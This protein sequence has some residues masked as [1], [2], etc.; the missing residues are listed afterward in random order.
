MSPPH[1]IRHAVR[2]IHKAPWFTA[3]SVAVLGLGIGA[4]TAIFSLV[5]AAL[6]R[7]L[8]FR[9]A[10][11]L[12]MIWER[13]ARNPRNVV[14]LQTFAD[15][16]D[17]S[18]TLAGVAA[19]AG[20]VQIP[21]ARSAEDVPESV[22]LESVTPS[23]FTVLGV[24]PLLGRFP[25]QSNVYV[26]GQSDGG[27]AISERLWRTRFGADPSIVGGTIRLGS[28]PRPVPVVGILPVGFQPLGSTDI[29][30]VISVDGASNAR[31]TRVLRVIGRMRPNTTLDQTRA[32]LI[33]IA[34]NIEQAY[35]ATN[36]GWSVTVEPLQAAIVGADLR[37]TSLVLGGVVLFVLLLAC[38]NIANLILA[39]GVGR[40][41]ELAVRA[42]LGGTRLRIAQ[43]LLVECV[44]LGVLGGLAG[45]AI[46]WALL[47]ATP[48]LI[49]PQTIPS[50][51]VLML[52]WR[53]V[54]F[55]SVTTV[56]TALLFGLA[57]AWQAARVS[58]VEAMNIGG[59]GASDRAGR[60][61]QALAVVEIA[62]ALLLMT[63]A[64]LLLRT[65][66]SLNDVDAGYRADNVVTMNIR[67]PFRRLVTA[68]PGEIETY[69][70]SIEREVAS[71]PAVRAASLGS[72]LP[73]AGA[74]MNPPFDIV[75]RPAADP[76]NRPAAHYQIVGPRYFETLGIQIVTGRAF[77]E[78]D[79][80]TA[81]QVCIVSDAFV[82]RFFAGRDPIGAQV[83]MAV[84][85]IRGQVVNREIVGVVRQVKT[86]PDEPADGANQIYVPAAQ[87][88]WVMANLIVRTADE[89]LQIVEQV[90]R[91]IARVDPTQAVTQVRTMEQIAE[92]STARPRVRAQLV[93][94]FAALATM[95]AAV[96]IFSVLMFM[97]QQRA[98]EFS[99]RLAVGATAGDLLR[100]V[101]E[102]GL[103]LT[104]IGVAIGVAASAALVRSLATLLF[105]VPP[106]DPVTFAV[107][108]LALTVVAV[109]A[110][111]A[112]A[113][114]ALHADPIAALRAE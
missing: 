11:Q 51:I 17:S 110:C 28:P 3:A 92:Q 4:T 97:V 43:Q 73:L 76:A 12:V 2:L 88:P 106:L 62:I 31:A 19:T 20:I 78:R 112:P 83:T 113:L 71:V 27:I 103:K 36:K 105:G 30:E 10:H 69:W 37:T 94:A 9:D 67:L 99:V 109:L 75:G 48:S 108:P 6:L 80:E 8:P 24:R 39:R 87:S 102:S 13:S 72:D 65:L 14:S 52:D 114:R 33:A 84:P 42:A 15:W 53:L 60:V 68:K 23:F 49:P 57:P 63:G 86:R 55:A 40:T 70:R 45:V 58:L 107:A 90:K 32:E 111:L 101:L 64:G 1:D 47:R 74:S 66:A 98:R 91:A 79:S 46:A 96:G 34:R 59:R 18:K 85:G 93:V 61:R 35:P 82:R 22:P 26:P 5:D 100:L 104:A 95:L 77:T 7:P 29:W 56:V 44:F 38:A 41:R 89:P 54:A 81:G 25:D 50:S 21:I 16:R